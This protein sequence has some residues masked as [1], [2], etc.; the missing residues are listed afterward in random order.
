MNILTCDSFLAFNTNIRLRRK[1][2]A[3]VDVLLSRNCIGT[4]HSTSE[5]VFVEVGP[6]Q[7]TL[8]LGYLSPKHKYETRQKV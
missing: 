4:F 8:S 5:K 2:K 1:C 3:N 6:L 7:C